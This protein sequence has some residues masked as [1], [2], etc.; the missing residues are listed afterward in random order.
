MRAVIDEAHKHGLR[1]TA[2]IFDL[3]DAKGLCVP[4]STRSPT[5]FATRTWTTSRWHVQGASEPRVTPNLPDRGVK[6]DLSWLRAGLPAAEFAKLEEANNDEPKAQAVHGDP[7][8]QPGE[9]ECGGRA[10]RARHRRQHAHGP[11]RGD[12]G[13]GGWPG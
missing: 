13:H 1:V 11:A 4:G 8:A 5:A 2:H 12:G 9:A 7:G 3:E 6:M 10:H